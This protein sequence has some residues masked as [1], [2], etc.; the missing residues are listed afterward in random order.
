MLNIQLKYSQSNIDYINL[1]KLSPKVIRKDND[2][3]FKIN[4]NTK[5]RRDFSWRTEN[6]LNQSTL[7]DLKDLCLLS[8][9]HL[10]DQKIMII[11][12][13]IAE[14]EQGPYVTVESE[15][16]V[17]SG[18]VRVIKVGSLPCRYVRLTIKKG[19]PIMDFKKVEFFGLHINQIKDKY[20]EE[21]LDILFY[22]TYDMIYRKEETEEYNEENQ[23]NSEY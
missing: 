11:K 12:L 18:K 13:E 19:Y 3:F 21:T 5:I 4:D 10:R 2:R 1:D 16:C 17:I 6:N 14:N 7:F 23:E 22:N 9:I 20:D 8:R 15:L